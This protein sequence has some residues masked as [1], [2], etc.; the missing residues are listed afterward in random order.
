M[1]SSNQTNKPQDFE[2]SSLTDLLEQH[3]EE[4]EFLFVKAINLY[5]APGS[6]GLSD[7]EKVD[8]LRAAVEKS[9]EAN[10]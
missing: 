7:R 6:D 1:S 2:I 8:Q 5:A 9:L 10:P 3:D 4:M